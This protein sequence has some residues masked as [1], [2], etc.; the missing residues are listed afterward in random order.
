VESHRQRLLA[1]QNSLR[2]ELAR[3]NF[4]ITGSV[5]TVLNAVFVRTTPDRLT[6]LTALPGVKGVVRMRRMMPKLDR[7]AVLVNAQGA[8][9]ALGG[10]Q[11]AGLGMKIA[12]ID[13]GIDQTHPAFQDNSLAVPSGF[14][15]CGVPADCAFTNHKVIVARSYVQPALPIDPTTSRP[16]DYS[17]RDHVGHGTGVAMAAA[18]E[19]NTGPADTIEGI[20]PK[21]FLGSYKV[22]GSPGVNDGAFDDQ[23]ISAIE[24][25]V[26]DGMNVAVLS[27]GGPALSGPLDVG[28]ACGLTGTTPCDPEAVAIENATKSGLLVVAAGGNEGSTG[29]Q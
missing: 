6:E 18:G 23:I 22:F 13:S 3:R 8:W 16:D 28:P 20:A 24:D 1:A 14:P 21:A 4:N 2:S 19:R 9:N 10:D 29:T 26:K 25:A 12:I 5:E 27:L 17:P 11:K 15:K 7:A